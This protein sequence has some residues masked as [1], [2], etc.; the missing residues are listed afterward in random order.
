MPVEKGT[1][2]GEGGL[3]KKYCEQTDR[4][5]GWSTTKAV[6]VFRL[7]VLGQRPMVHS[8]AT[9]GIV[10]VG[11]NGNYPVPISGDSN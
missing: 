9:T 8:C 11:K 3:G 2:H 5:A 10:P 1:A 6:R 4:A 7:N